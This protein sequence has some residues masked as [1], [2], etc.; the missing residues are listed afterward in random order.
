MTTND[1]PKPCQKENRALLSLIH[2]FKFK[3]RCFRVGRGR[4]LAPVQLCIDDTVHFFLLYMWKSL[5]L[6]VPF[7]KGGV[8]GMKEKENPEPR[9]RLE[10][11]LSCNV[12]DK[13]WLSHLWWA[14][15]GLLA[16]CNCQ[17]SHVWIMYTFPWSSSVSQAGYDPQKIKAARAVMRHSEVSHANQN[18][19]PWQEAFQVLHVIVVFM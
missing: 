5:L 16:S 14:S 10:F 8:G 17:H 13:R 6:A 2:P 9:I 1:L 4:G 12:S 3:W 18:K 15:R 19:I 7:L 11:A